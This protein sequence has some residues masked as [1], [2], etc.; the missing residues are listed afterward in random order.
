M[1]SV[2]ATR[3]MVHIY[4]AIRRLRNKYISLAIKK[5]AACSSDNFN[6]DGLRHTLCARAG[7]RS[8]AYIEHKHES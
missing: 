7:G 3:E 4:G 2:K 1:R 8:N 6:V 5:V